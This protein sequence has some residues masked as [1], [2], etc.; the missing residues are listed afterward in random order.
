[1]KG[2]ERRGIELTRSTALFRL[3][4]RHVL[5][6]STGLHHA[7]PDM[8]T[9]DSVCDWEAMRTMLEE[10]KPAWRPGSRASY[11]YYTFGWLVAGIVEK[12]SGKSFGE[13]RCNVI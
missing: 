6:H 1:M 3:Q 10:A 2:G 7:F 4:V 8:A 9:F 13:V 11:H 5:T 12:A